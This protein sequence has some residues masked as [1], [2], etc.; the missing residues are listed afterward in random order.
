MM[1]AAEGQPAKKKI[2]PWSQRIVI[3]IPVGQ[4]KKLCKKG[5]CK[6]VQNWQWYELKKKPDIADIK[7]FDTNG[8]EVNLRTLKALLRKV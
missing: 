8:K 3:E 2:G 5:R 6:T 7:L 1:A 4:F